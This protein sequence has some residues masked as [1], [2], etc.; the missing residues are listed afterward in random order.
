MIAPSLLVLPVMAGLK[1][2]L[3]VMA[4]ALLP[5]CIARRVLIRLAIPGLAVLI[6]KFKLLRIRP[7]VMRHYGN[8]EKQM[9]KTTSVVVLLCAV[10]VMFAAG[11]GS[12]KSGAREGTRDGV[13]TSD[14]R[15]VGYNL[16]GGSVQIIA[17]FVEGDITITASK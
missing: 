14:G 7:L 10:A 16:S 17:D 3:M 12:V 5:A 9:K 1:M 13:N 15:M 11:C 8:K 2:E 4:Q 6:A